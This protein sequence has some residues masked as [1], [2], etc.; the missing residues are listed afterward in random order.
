VQSGTHHVN[1]AASGNPDAPNARVIRP[2][3][4]GAWLVLLR[5]RSL[6][7][8]VSPVLVGAAVGYARTGAVDPIATSL[9]L[10]GAVLVQAISNMQNDVG[11]T[12]RGGE[13][14]GTRTGLPRATAQGWL[15]VRE[16]RMT[17]AI[18]SVVA[19]GIGIALFVH[20][21][22]PVLA[23]GSASLLAALAYM[24]GPRPIAYTPFGELIV[25]AFFGLVAVLGT[26]WVVTAGV[27]RATVVAGIAIGCLAAAA[28]CVNNHRDIMHDRSV[29]RRTFAV[30]F[31]PAASRRL[32][33][34]LLCGAFVALPAMV[35]LAHG[36]ARPGPHGSSVWLLLPLALA[37]A[38][39]RLWHDFVRCT[40]GSAFNAILFRTFRLELA[41]AV[42]LAVGAMLERLLR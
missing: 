20:R 2:G 11:Y 36:G 42:L 32:Y 7:V 9:V 1:A 6:L 17:I 35:L 5:L 31:G 10:A 39:K 4:L 41:F 14:G 40:P 30:T 28:L 27:G 25:F 24:G 3:S 12:T 15:G 29:G 26:D 37:P 19:T 18:T 13:R 16:V 34:I 21:G 23:I 38:A 8:A 22:W 33:A